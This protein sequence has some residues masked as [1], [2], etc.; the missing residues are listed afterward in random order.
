MSLVN[1]VF[2]VR[3]R[4]VVQ[5]QGVDHARV[6]LALENGD[7]PLSLPWEHTAT[8]REVELIDIQDL[9]GNNPVSSVT[10]LSGVWGYVKPLTPPLLVPPPPIP[11][12]EEDIPF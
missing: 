7:P 2:E 1:L 4:I 11:I 9:L 8:G 10:V 5:A 6:K 3:Q 12:K